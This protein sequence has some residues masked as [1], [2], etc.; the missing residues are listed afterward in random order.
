MGKEDIKTF[1]DISELD[2][3]EQQEE[4]DKNESEEE[5]EDENERLKIKPPK[6]YVDRIGVSL[7]DLSVTQKTYETLGP[8]NFETDY[9]GDLKKVVNMTAE[10]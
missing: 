10:K 8:F 2:K 7:Y 1:I 9:K 5:I 4:E 6:Y 3:I